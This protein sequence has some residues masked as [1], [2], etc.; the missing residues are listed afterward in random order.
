M[1][2]QKLTARPHVDGNRIEITWT[3][4]ALPTEV[5][6]FRSSRSHPTR[7]GEGIELSDVRAGSAVDRGLHGETVY[8]YSRFHQVERRSG[9][10]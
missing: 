1:R 10:D 3:V 2:L 8:Y 7:I 9:L 5:R 6:V 4:P